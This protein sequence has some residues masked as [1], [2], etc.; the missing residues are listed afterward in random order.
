M[1]FASRFGRGL[2]WNQ[3]SRFLELGAAYAL[4][5]IAA[6]AL[7]PAAFGVYSVAIS[8]VTLSYFATS[9]GLN[10]VLNVQVP[11]LR[12]QPGRVGFLLRALLAR[13]AAIALG[14]AL[15][16]ALGAP[17]A[18]RAWREPALLPLLRVA[19]VYAFFYNVSFLFEYFHMGS[20]E[21]PRVSRARL[22][23]QGLGLAAGIAALAGHWPAPRL[24]GAVALASA[25]G[26]LWLAWGARASLR[27]PAE[28]FDLAPL[29][30]FGLAIWGTNFLA[31]FLGRQSDVLLI[32][33][34]RPG[35]AEAGCY[36]V[37]ALLVNLLASA[38]LMGAEGVS[39]A[40]FSELEQRVDR[41]SL[42]RLW[43]FH[44]KVDQL[45]SIP[46]LLFGARFAPA[47]VATLYAK[48]FAP[49]A[50]LLQA[51]AVAWVL[52]RVT[53]GGTNMTVL[54]AIR[55]P[56]APLL[57]YG[58]GGLVNVALDVLLIPRMG[59]MGAVIGTGVAIVGSSI[60]SSVLVARH[61]GTPLPMRFTFELLG[62][63]AAALLAVQWLPR[64]GGLAG[65]LVA[66]AAGLVVLLAVIRMLR[67]LDA[68]DTA[69]LVRLN[70]R[71]GALALRLQGGAK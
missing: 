36:A 51:Y 6:R 37:A 28:R 40:A 4:S 10:E 9:L 60:A 42:G 71:L 17:W 62:A 41:A 24:L 34:F 31:F 45:L 64:P 20:M 70:P 5:V 63:C 38:L 54:Y 32:G 27:A 15:A 33:W 2:L 55:R 30:R 21:V 57:L 3:V 47:I 29:T 19:A 13:R 8:A 18:A 26:C 14:L 22:L 43:A 69:L 1:S 39:L 56:R 53:G 11:R 61:T 35:T 52:A 59:A 25:L 65:L 67:P 16:F 12:E 66:G 48:G 44:L 68:D 23:V 49:A 7:G 50:V 46:L 58:L